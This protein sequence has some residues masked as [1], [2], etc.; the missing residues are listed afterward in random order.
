MEEENTKGKRGGYRP[1][2]G[3]K[4]RASGASKAIRVPETISDHVRRIC[5]IYEVFVDDPNKKASCRK[6]MLAAIDNMLSQKRKVV[7]EDPRQLSIDW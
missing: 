7:E 6:Q 1:G 5:E 3:R 4:G 2:S